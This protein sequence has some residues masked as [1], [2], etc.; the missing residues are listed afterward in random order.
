MYE[1]CFVSPVYF[2]SLI[3]EFQIL[4]YYLVIIVKSFFVDAS[5]YYNFGHHFL[6]HGLTDFI[7]SFLKISILFSVCY[8]NLLMFILNEMSLFQFCEYD[9][10][11]NFPHYK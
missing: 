2:K 11:M 10:N 6:I 7:D 3:Y 8:C 5:S 4:C 1:K 9:E